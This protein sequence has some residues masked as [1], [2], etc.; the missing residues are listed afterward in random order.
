M[1]WTEGPAGFVAAAHVVCVY[2][3]LRKYSACPI[4]ATGME[5]SLRISRQLCWQ[6][7][8][9]RKQ[10]GSS[11]WIGRAWAGPAEGELKQKQFAKSLT[12]EPSEGGRLEWPPLPSTSRSTD[13]CPCRPFHKRLGCGCQHG[14]HSLTVC[15]QGLFTGVARL[16]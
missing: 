13:T 7:H 4:N 3:P 1:T 12:E 11:G 16:Q 15:R 8:V 10:D 2:H 14:M 5:G 6:S 9:H